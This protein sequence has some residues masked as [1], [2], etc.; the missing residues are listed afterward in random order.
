MNSFQLVGLPYESFSAMFDWPDRDLAEK[1]IR[2]V[3]ADTPLGYPC[4]VSLV[5]AEPGEVLLLLPYAHL[6]VQSPYQ[7]SGPIFVREGA[8][9]KVEAAGW[10][11]PYVTQRLISARAYDDTGMMIEAQVCEGADTAALMRQ[12]F[13]NRQV[14]YIHLHNARPGC[15]SCKAIR[16]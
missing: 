11:P 2:K 3:I 5:D 14:A 1:N 13:D 8:V 15:F 9:Q 4:R 7:A 16:A 6:D 10:V 12:M